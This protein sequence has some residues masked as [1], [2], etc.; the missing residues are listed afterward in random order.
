LAGVELKKFNVLD[1]ELVP[2]HIILN[3][4]EKEE[5][6]KKYGISL[7]HL[8]RILITDP[9]I[10]EMNPKIGDMIKIIRKSQT[11]GESVYYRVVIKG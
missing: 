10:K 7:R 3:E 4:Q 6:L 9:A 1:H 8:P 2:K 11:A 5:T